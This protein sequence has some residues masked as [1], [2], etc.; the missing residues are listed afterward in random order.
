MAVLK[1]TLK[2]SL[3]DGISARARRIN[4]ALDSLQRRTSVLNGTFGRV[5]AFAATYVGVTEGF[6]KTYNSAADA[7]T[8]MT[9][10]G[11]KAGLSGT[12]LDMMQQRLTKLSKSTNQYASDLTAGVDVMLGMGLSADDAMGSIGAVGKA[13]TATGATMD[14]LAAASVSA[15]QNLKVAPS[16]IGRML[17][18]MA[19]AGN[20]GAFELKDMAAYIPALGAA[21]QGLGQTGVGAVNDLASAL[22]IVRQG[23]GDSASAAGNLGNVLQKI[24]APQTRAAFKKMG[25]NLA[26]EMKAA[27]AKGMSPIEAIAEVTNKTLKGD[28]GKLGDLFADSE[29]Q[30]GLR[31]LI[32]NMAE[33]RR[34][35]DEANA[36]TGTIA[37]AYVR[38]ME[39]AN[40]KTKH[41]GVSL[42]NL[43]TSIGDNL[44]RP[45]SDFA[46][47]MSNILDT[48]DSRVTVFDRIGA[49]VGGFLSGAGIEGGDLGAA[50]K[51]WKEFLFG[52]EDGSKAADQIGGIFG[53][54][55]GYGAQIKW[56]TDTVKDS[57][58]IKFLG[59]MAGY[60][61]A[62]AVTAGSI[63]LLAGTLRKL[64]RAMAVLSGLT[65]VI[66]LLKG[67][68]NARGAV[69]G[70]TEAADLAADFATEKN[71]RKRKPTPRT[72][73]DIPTS[74]LRGFLN[75][76]NTAS[77]AA[78]LPSDEGEMK[79]F[80]EEN[81]KRWDGYSAW[82]EKHVGSPK[83]LLNY[84][85][86][87]HPYTT[88]A[89]GVSARPDQIS[90]FYEQPADDGSV[91][92]RPGQSSMLFE[93]QTDD[94]GVSG[95]R[96]V[97]IDPSSISALNQPAGTQDVRVTNPQPV[98]LNVTVNQTISGAGDAKA[99]ADNAAAKMGAAT[100]AAVESSLGGGGGF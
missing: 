4:G 90:P 74:Y 78:S 46:D 38:Q 50:A 94:G 18:G 32:Q 98:A 23:T 11:I 79:T 82:L 27:T 44:L 36:A 35:R 2:L 76:L 96:Q 29:V 37:D 95:R 13:A 80:M 31:P 28:L 84:R 49:A 21:Y 72:S 40:Q 22:Q 71:N 6:E 20:A 26:K 81:K 53:K 61:L 73:P 97:V 5:A 30:K 1:S 41:L 54:F 51:E 89:D 87:G 45:V 25:V 75:L 33:F 8:A 42:T 67:I 64:G 19:S 69:V 100:K 99:V 10:I 55:Q 12:Q 77:I 7:E 65:T 14:D 85:N 9:N 15:M 59:D 66:D 92:A 16:E 43:G 3:L 63:G 52:V 34:I 60:G 58:L 70:A 86:S 62:L 39:T 48:L 17:D 83:N 57:P 68:K 47:E 93:R 88:G 56:L 91:S 24:N